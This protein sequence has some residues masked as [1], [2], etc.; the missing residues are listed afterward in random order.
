MQW[1]FSVALGFDNF[2]VIRHGGNPEKHDPKVRGIRPGCYFCN[3]YLSPTN[4]MKDRSL[5][6]QCT[7]T[8][9]GL[10]FLSTAYASELLVNLIH[11][12]PHEYASETRD[13][14]LSSAEFGLIPQHIRGSA[15]GFNVELMSSEC[16]D[17]C[18]A[19]GAQIVSEY[20]KDKQNLVLKACNSPNYL[21]EASGISKDLEISEGA[22]HD[23]ICFDDEF[24]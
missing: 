3:D 2:I 23:I 24:V 4:T 19:C 14:P 20:L 9:P 8:R 7:V 10:S 17:N 21:Q 12:L 16:Y 5:D 11:T 15:S 6:M 18:L 22:H 13:K 1:C